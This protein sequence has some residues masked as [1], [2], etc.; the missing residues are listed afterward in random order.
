[1]EMV[2]A[3]ALVWLFC[4]LRSNEIIRLRVGCIRWQH[5]NKCSTETNSTASREA[6]CWLDVPVNKTYRS[7][8]K[9]VDRLVGEAIDLWE[10]V[11][12]P[13]P[14]ALDSKTGAMVNFLFSYR[15]VRIG[16]QYLNCTLIPM[17]C[18]KAGV[19]ESDARGEITSHR[20]RSTIA[21]QLYNAREPMSLFD[22]QEW[23]GHTHLESTQYYARVTPTKLAKK[24]AEAGY[25][26]RNVRTVE[27]LIDR[28]AILSG[29]SARGE[30]WQYYDLGHGWCTNA[31]FVECPH[32]MACP[33]CQFYI[34]KD[35]AKGHFL[36][37]QSNL[38]T[39]L[40]KIPLTEDERAAVEE[41]IDL[42][43][44]LCQKLIDVPTPAGPTPREL[45]VDGRRSLPVLPASVAINTSAGQPRQESNTS[46]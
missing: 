43:D 1:M 42:F 24:Y 13:Q 29:D 30:P 20:A 31:Y 12:P 19:P 2:R 16:D 23:L 9:P 15:G 45:A 22:L 27:V 17:L 40:Q 32:R 4:G 8:T 14:K 44:K 21:T 37:S 26:E 38:Q 5:E 36:E 3:V 39:M 28:D 35:S 25:F 41:G 7:F 33:K 11:R 34:A 46:G 6:I 10:R 18:R